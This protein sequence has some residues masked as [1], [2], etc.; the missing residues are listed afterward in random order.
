MYDL[1]HKEA[2]EYLDHLD[3]G[4]RLVVINPNYDCQ[5]LLVHHLIQ[6]SDALYLRFEGSNLSG[7]QLNSQIGSA[8]AI[9]DVRAN[10]GGT[11]NIVLDECDRA[12]PQ[13]LDAFLIDLA[14][15]AK[16]RRIFVFSRILPTYVLA[17][18]EWCQKTRFI[19]H[20]ENLMFWDYAQHNRQ[21]M[22]LLEVRALGKGRVLLN[23][24]PVDEWDG[25]LPRSLFF[26]L[27]DKGM[28]TRNEI[29]E[30]FWPG[31]SVREATNVFHVTKRK[32][33]EVLG[34]DLTSY[35]SGF[36]HISDKIQ[37]SYD[38]VQFSQMIQDSGV[39]SIED[40]TKLL[41]RAA[42][43]YR[44][45]FLTTMNGM[46]WVIRR[47]QEL[48][49]SYGEAL[50]SLAKFLEKQGSKEEALG[51]FLRASTTNRRR[52][53]VV[54]S[55]MQIYRD[56]EMLEDALKVYGHLK[57]ELAET[58]DVAPDK[59]LQELAETIRQHWAV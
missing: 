3:P 42:G 15:R 1:L 33:S 48:H 23:G 39:A 32:I 21:E 58:L 18:D 25:V 8:L 45:Q 17:N 34:I 44:D 54:F 24:I 52:E 51:L 22:T 31:L 30:T 38:V 7:L 59:P 13:A 10:L 26:Y 12:Q 20:D 53:D 29:F 41:R 50:V 55:A 35:W 47:R 16:N 56:L 49:Q 27:V 14:E 36:Y 4:I 11:G 6:E 40:A 57:S 2:L 46:D 28:T 37:L 43:L 9:Q 19:P 5:R